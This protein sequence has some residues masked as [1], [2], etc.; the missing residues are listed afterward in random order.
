MYISQVKLFFKKIRIIVRWLSI[1][2]LRLS[3]QKFAGSHQYWSIDVWHYHKKHTSKGW[4]K[5]CICF[6]DED[7]ML[8]ET[9]ES[10]WNLHEEEKYAS[11]DPWD[12]GRDQTLK[13][14]PWEITDE[15]IGN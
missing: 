11:I 13:W 14:R 12:N 4:C 15:Y 5:G 10:W 8:N 3:Y 7:S 1:I 6:I 2:A 9:H